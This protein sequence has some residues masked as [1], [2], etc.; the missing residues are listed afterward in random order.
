MR[1]SELFERAMLELPTSGRESSFWPS[2]RAEDSESCGNHPGATD[3]LTGATRNWPTPHGLT[4][5]DPAGNP[6]GGGEFA[7]AI[8]RWPTPN[9]NPEAPNNS[10]ARENGRQANRETDQCLATRAEAAQSIWMTP[11]CPSGGGR[12]I[13][14]ELVDAKGKTDDGK[15]RQIPLDAQAQFWSTPK[16]LTGGPDANE[17]MRKARGAGGPD[18]Q[19]QVGDWPT[20][21]A[22]QRG[23]Y[24]QS[25]GP[26]GARPTIVTAATNWPTPNSRDHRG[27]DIPGRNGGASLSHATETGEFSHTKPKNW[28]TPT[29]Q[30]D[31]AM[32]GTGQ[33]PEARKAAGHTVNL[34]DVVSTFSPSS[35]QDQPTHDG[36]DSLKNIPTSPRPS[37][38]TPSESGGTSR[39]DLLQRKRLNPAFV[40]LLMGWP[41]FWTNP[42]VTS[43]AKAEM[44]LYRR[45][46]DM[47]LSGLLSGSES[48]A[49]R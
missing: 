37:P 25:P 38:P 24:N 3:S 13:S 2:A 19:A 7:A 21:D 35:P 27:S 15:K 1:K 49:A 6:N 45:R 33:D 17:K 28:P 16:T 42:G 47:R 31:N 39:P 4:G 29:V 48:R 36:L 10:P 5:T 20:P 23:G 9:A 34:Q 44:V 26:A 14:K 11:N 22:G 30:S 41:W 43:Y 32:R 18:L 12:V 8:E 40:N 46:L